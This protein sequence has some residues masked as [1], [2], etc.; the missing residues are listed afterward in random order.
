ME[1][2]MLKYDDAVKAIQTLQDILHEPFSVIVRDAAIQRFVYTFEAFWKFFK[3]YLKDAEGVV[4]GSPKACFRELFSAG[5]CSEEE[6][7]ILLEMTDK[8]NETS[9]TYKEAVAQD[10]FENVGRYQQL[11]SKILH[12][13]RVTDYKRKGL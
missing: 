5:L 3:E 12:Q 8:R 9:H 13:E 7:V 2:L 1:R 11:M 10:I 4:V 6:T